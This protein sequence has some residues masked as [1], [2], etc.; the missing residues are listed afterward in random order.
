[1]ASPGK[2]EL[3]GMFRGADIKFCGVVRTADDLDTEHAEVGGLFYVEDSKAG[4]IFMPDGWHRVQTVQLPDGLVIPIT[5]ASLLE[6]MYDVQS[7]ND[8]LACG[9][10]EEVP[11]TDF[12]GIIE[13]SDELP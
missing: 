5:D 9:H 10:G 6:L 4:A 7:L 12:E 3:K 13:E 1:M 8:D 11:F 2:E